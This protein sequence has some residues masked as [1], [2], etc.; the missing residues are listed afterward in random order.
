MPQP[1]KAYKPQPASQKRSAKLSAKP[2]NTRPSTTSTARSKPTNPTQR[3]DTDLLLL[4]SAQRTLL[5]PSSPE[6]YLLHALITAFPPT[7]T[8]TTDS[9]A[10]HLRTIKTHFFN[11]NYAAIFTTESLLPVYAAEYIPSRALCYR[12]M[13]M[14]V[15][16]VREVMVKGGKMC[17]LGAGNGSELVGVVA[18]MCGM[19][20]FGLKKRIPT[21]DESSS[22]QA[23]RIPSHLEVHIQDLANYGTVLPSLLASLQQHYPT[24]SSH[25]HLTTSV[26]DLLQPT[27][28][29][30]TT[31]KETIST[32]S[33]TTAMFLLNELLTTN[34]SAFVKFITLLMDALTPGSLLLVVDSAGSFSECSVGGDAGKREYMVYQLL[35]NMRCLETV[36]SED[37]IW[38]RF[39]E[40]L[41]YPTRLNNMRYFLRLYRKA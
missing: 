7:P 12:E 8:T 13:F 26:S 35:D 41:R 5:S 10:E 11:R 15:K 17:C 18:A 21:T 29:Q 1:T 27:P 38:Y 9:T 31:L 25:V 33:L 14:R 24:A 22:P 32:S 36:E 20:V 4:H 34:K 16:A 19:E 6:Q 39:P 37:A 3:D 30:I 2:Q 23:P 28:T 40:G